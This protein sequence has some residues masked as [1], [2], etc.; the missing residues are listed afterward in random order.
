[1]TSNAQ[2]AQGTT[3][4]ISSTA[5]GAKTITAMTLSNP[6]IL[7]SVGHGL[8]NGDVVTLADFAGADA[9]TLNGKVVAIRNVTTDTFAVDID[10]TGLTIT[11]NTDT[12]TA[13]PLSWATVGEIVSGA[14]FDGTSA[15]IDKTNLASTAK[16]KDIGLEDFGTLKLELQ[17]YDADAGQT[18]MRTAKSN[19]TSKNFKVT[20]PN[21]ETRTFAGFVMSFTESFGVDQM[22]T[23]STEILIDGEVTYG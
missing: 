7:T 8:A 10:T 13:T 21:G 19:Q 22:V 16:E 20:Y 17:I 1:M 2:N 3:L 4:Q 9:A 14:G 6:T 15:V 11:D 5:G 12:A 18:A 23:G